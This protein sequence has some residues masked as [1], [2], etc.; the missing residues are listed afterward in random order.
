M[1]T[2]LQVFN[3]EFIRS[4]FFKSFFSDSLIIRRLLQN[5]ALAKDNEE[6]K[7]NTNKAKHLISEIYQALAGSSLFELYINFLFNS[8]E[9]ITYESKFK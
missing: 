6:L 1:V 2:K 7:I 9:E 5:N 3:L 4:L 8:E